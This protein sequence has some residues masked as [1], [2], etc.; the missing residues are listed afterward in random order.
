MSSSL[1]GLVTAIS[2]IF[3]GSSHHF[4]APKEEYQPNNDVQGIEFNLEKYP[5]Y[6][7][8]LKTAKNS[9]DNRADSIGYIYSKMIKKWGPLEFKGGYFLGVS[10]GYPDLIKDFPLVP[11]GAV[12]LDTKL[13]PFENIPLFLK[14]NLSCLPVACLQEVGAQWDF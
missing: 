2:I 10:T 8:Y 13:R 14:Y 4:D 12:R 9:F 5:D 1:L 11:V 3:N 7:F 6:G